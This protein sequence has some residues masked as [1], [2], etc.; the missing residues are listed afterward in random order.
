MW[1]VQ[2]LSRCFCY[3]YLSYRW[4]CILRVLV[5]VLLTLCEVVYCYSFS[6]SCSFHCCWCPCRQYLCCC[7]IFII[8]SLLCLSKLQFVWQA[9]NRSLIYTNSATGMRS[10]KAF[11]G[12]ATPSEFH[13]LVKFSIGSER[14][15]YQ[16]RY[17]YP[18]FPRCCQ[19]F[20][21]ANCCW[22]RYH[23]HVALV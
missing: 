6:F 19:S 12:R 5:V 21:C 18:K 4:F 9:M 7:C 16:C 11:N 20:H 23:A 1:E 8:V 14:V 3:A 15:Q 10:S 13:I 17:R 22:H 2:I